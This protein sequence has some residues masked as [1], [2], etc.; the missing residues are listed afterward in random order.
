MLRRLAYALR[1]SLWYWLVIGERS[2]PRTH[3]RKYGEL[4]RW[5]T[6]QDRETGE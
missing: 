2:D 5:L 1:K 6:V 4:A 3:W